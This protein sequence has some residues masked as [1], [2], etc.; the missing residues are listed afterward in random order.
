MTKPSNKHSPGTTTPTGPTG[1]TGTTDVPVI[2]PK[3]ED[4]DNNG[5][6]GGGHGNGNNSGNGG[7]NKKKTKQAVI[8]PVKVW[9]EGGGSVVRPGSSVNMKVSVKN[10]GDLTARNV[11]VYMGK[12]ALAGR[13]SVQ[14]KRGFNIRTLTPG[15]TVTGT[16]TVVFG[17]K[18][19]GK[20]AI[21]AQAWGN[22]GRKILH[23]R[24]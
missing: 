4:N 2:N 18:A 7:N 13:P 3:P 9:M 12:K 21:T 17:R 10:S 22:W 16:V 11:F 20:V 5:N 8:K 24:R 19:R 14:I 1:P 6:N 23:I 15:W